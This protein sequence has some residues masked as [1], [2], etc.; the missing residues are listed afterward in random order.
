MHIASRL[1]SA[2]PSR[3]SRPGVPRATPA[4]GRRRVLAR[5]VAS[6]ALGGVA[7]VVAGALIVAAAPTVMA[8][9]VIPMPS[10][11]A[12]ASNAG[13]AAS[14]GAAMVEPVSA[15]LAPAMAAA[16]APL[17]DREADRR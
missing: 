16:V 8:P 13:A 14:N 5:T 4:P 10:A 2:A 15:V 7:G 1:A 3:A 9:P 11:A 6:A 17:S 12:T